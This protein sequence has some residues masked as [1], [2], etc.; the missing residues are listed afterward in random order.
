MRIEFSFNSTDQLRLS[1]ENARDKQL[2]QLFTDGCREI[3]IAPGSREKPDTLV[4]EAV[5]VA[6]VAESA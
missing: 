2:I 6:A 5:R 3:R 1:P 4:I